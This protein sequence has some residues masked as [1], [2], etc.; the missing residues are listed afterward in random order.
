MRLVLDPGPFPCKNRGPNPWT[1]ISTWATKGRCARASST[2][3]GPRCARCRR[4]RGSR[5]R[6][7]WRPSSASRAASSSRPTRS[8]RPRATCSRAA[9]A[10]RSSR[11]PR[12]RPPR[13]PRPRPA[14]L[15]PPRYDLRPTLPA[16]D[17]AF[18]PAW[19]KALNR[20]LRTTPDARLGYPDPR[21]EPELRAVLASSL[22]RRRGVQATPDDVRV[23]AGLGPSLPFVWR[24]LRERGVRRVA[25]EDPCWPRLPASL[26]QAG[27]EP[28]PLEVDEH[29]MRVDGLADGRRRLRHPRAPVPD[30]HGPLPRAAR[31]VD[32][33]GAQHGRARARGRLRRR[34]PLRPPAG[35][36]AAGARAR[37]RHLRRVDLQDARA[38]AAARL[39][40]AARRTSG[41]SRPARPRCSTS[42]RSPTCS[43]AA[44]S[45]ATCATTAASTSGAGRRCWPRSPR[46]CRTSR[47]PAPPPG[48]HAVLHLPDAH[49]VAEAAK[50]HGV[51]LEA[52]GGKLIVGYANLPESQAP[53]AVAALSHARALY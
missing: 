47:S 45:T 44:T 39:A 43:S 20:A 38:R 32:R 29:G 6:G 50:A 49:A 19:G 8:S 28:V 48:L 42:S 2:R 22:A 1:S 35:R 30:R 27:L 14:T 11:T 33:V 18:R 37:R 7:R 10:G 3:C 16:L 15:R 12:P 4:T 46:R 25:I 5:P 23:T 36:L 34:V 52:M 24:L 21:G 41:P 53:A 17:G 26:E 31:R 13:P 9:A 51:A 40:R